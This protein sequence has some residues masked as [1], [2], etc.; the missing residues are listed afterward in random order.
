MKGPDGD[1]RG[2]PGLT[3]QCKEASWTL[4]AHAPQ[5]GAASLICSLS[6]S[7][8]CSPLRTRT[9]VMY[10]LKIKPDVII[11]WVA[12]LGWVLGSASHPLCLDRWEV[13][14]MILD[15]Q[16][17]KLRLLAVGRFAYYDCAA[18]RWKNWDLNPRLAPR[19]A[20][21]GL[22]CYLIVIQAGPVVGRIMAPKDAM[23]KS[24]MWKGTLQGYLD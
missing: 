10:H 2:R 21:A 19:K 5:D 4:P 18:H 13:G 24:L 23:S 1:Q 20:W 7:I 16:M 8:H 9:C 6:L 12:T 3:A 14:M 15:L 17:R 22:L 11:Y